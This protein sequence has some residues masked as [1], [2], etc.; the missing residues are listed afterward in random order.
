MYSIKEYMILKDII[1]EY[2]YF[3]K[4]NKYKQF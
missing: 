3:L 1:Q 2:P 4:I